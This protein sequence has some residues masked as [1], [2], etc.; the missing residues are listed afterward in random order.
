MT[1]CNPEFGC[2]CGDEIRRL[3]GEIDMLRLRLE[4]NTSIAV[5]LMQNQDASLGPQGLCSRCT[6]ERLGGCAMAVGYPACQS[7]SVWKANA[8]DRLEP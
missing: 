8:N 3:N 1:Y 2:D 4:V 6:T 5:G 7:Q